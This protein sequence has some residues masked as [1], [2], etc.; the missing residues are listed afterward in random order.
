MHFQY[1]ALSLMQPGN[2]NNFI[3][4]CNPF[5]SFSNRRIYFEPCIRGSF[6]ALHGSFSSLFE[7]RAKKTKW[8]K[9]IF[10]FW[11]DVPFMIFPVNV[12][13]LGLDD[14]TGW[15]AAPQPVSSSRPRSITFTGKIMK[16]T[17]CQKTNMYFLHLVF[18]ALLSKRL[19]KLPCRA[20]KEPLMHGSK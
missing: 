12:I 1:V 8:R 16:G 4:H 14:E 13:D 10:V 20:A 3:A 6:A 19:E 15:G 2:H 9:Y 18:F 11:H 17:S 5:K 7:R